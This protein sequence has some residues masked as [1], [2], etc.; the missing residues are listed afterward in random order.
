MKKILFVLFFF[1]NSAFAAKLEDVRVLDSTP[2]QEG[3]ELK[4][5][6]E[7]GPKK[8]YFFVHIVRSDPASFDKLALVI[9]KQK[10]GNHFKLTLDIPSFSISPPGSYYRSEGVSFSGKDLRN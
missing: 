7:N 2:S 9:E 10:K 5:R 4:L 3:L 8:S 1:L 6:V